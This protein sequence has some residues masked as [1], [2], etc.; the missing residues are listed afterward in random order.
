MQC[1]L[2]A[3]DSFGRIKDLVPPIFLGGAK[4]IEQ[5]EAPIVNEHI[6]IYILGLPP[7]PVTVANEGLIIIEIPKPKKNVSE[8]W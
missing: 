8:S 2:E 1:F 5:N 6:Y 3:S 4:K 7:H